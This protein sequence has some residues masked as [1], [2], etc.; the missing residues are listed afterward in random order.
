MAALKIDRAYLYYRALNYLKAEK[1]LESVLS[2]D[3]KNLS[4]LFLMAQIKFR[5]DD[6]ATAKKLAHDFERLSK[7]NASR[8]R[9]A[10]LLASIYRSESDAKQ[11]IKYSNFILENK[12]IL[13]PEDVLGAAEIA[14]D[15]EVNPK[16]R[17]LAVINKGILRIGKIHSLIK[18]SIGLMVELSCYQQAIISIDFLIGE[19]RGVYK[20]MLMKRKLNILDAQGNRKE[21]KF[22]AQRLMI[23]LDSLPEKKKSLSV[24]ADL[25][26]VIWRRV[27]QK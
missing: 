27:S 2:G 5:L 6:L 14:L 7:S 1:E 8:V 20:A 10:S 16:V 23:F 17:A 24:V 13:L 25:R 22:I 12:K 19:S 9:V 26:I 11:A 21:A 3:S 18:A 4:A 15:F